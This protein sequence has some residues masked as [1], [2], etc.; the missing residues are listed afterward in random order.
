MKPILLMA[1]FTLLT[2]LSGCAKDRGLAPPP[3]SEQVTVT[4][5][6]PQQPGSA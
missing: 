4:V 6:V 3:D 5:K 1:L 2:S